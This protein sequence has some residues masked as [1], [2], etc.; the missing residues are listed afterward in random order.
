[1]ETLST[2]SQSLRPSTSFDP[3]TIED[4]F[5]DCFYK[6]YNTLLKPNPVEPV[7]I[8]AKHSGEN[9]NIY[10]LAGSFPSTLHEVA[11]WLTAGSKRRK[12][13]DYGYWY[14]PNSRSEEEQILFEKF[15]AR[16]QAL[17]WI[18]ASSC[19]MDWI[20][21]YDNLELGAGDPLRFRKEI[22]NNSLTLICGGF[23]KRQAKFI[24][25]LCHHYNSKNNFN[26]YWTRIEKTKALPAI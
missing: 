23:T 13:H 26:D 7:Y 17:E 24:K 22:L 6:D 19:G 1:M 25:T 15:E 18:L 8:P 21:S 12:L 14:K 10:Y 5:K 20:A 9:D 11:H 16:N 4:L 2:T 3:K